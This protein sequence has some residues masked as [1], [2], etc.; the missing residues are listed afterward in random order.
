MAGIVFL[1]FSLA[2]NAYLMSAM[3]KARQKQIGIPVRWAQATAASPLTMLLP[4]WRFTRRPIA[5]IIRGIGS[6]EKPFKAEET[7]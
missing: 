6:R 4:L 2:L 7:V 3:L 1:V 5:E